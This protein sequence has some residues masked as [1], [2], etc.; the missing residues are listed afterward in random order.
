MDVYITIAGKYKRNVLKNSTSH[1]LLFILT[2]S[3]NLI[4][5][6]NADS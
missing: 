6:L 2:S 1:Y 4:I 5:I 3:D